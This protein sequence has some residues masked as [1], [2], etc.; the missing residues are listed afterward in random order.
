M[1]DKEVTEMLPLSRQM[2][3]RVCAGLA[4]A[5]LAGVKAVS[6]PSQVAEPE[7][8][9]FH[10]LRWHFLLR[11]VFALEHSLAAVNGRRWRA[12]LMLMVY[13]RARE[14]WHRLF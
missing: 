14:N 11:T 2:S 8:A 1:S 13:H 5:E 10:I 4:D 6:A 3:L 9:T 12:K 7:T